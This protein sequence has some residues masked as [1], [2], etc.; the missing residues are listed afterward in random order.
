MGFLD[1]FKA[2]MKAG[3][4]AADSIIERQRAEKAAAEAAARPKPEARPQQSRLPEGVVMVNLNRL[5]PIE[6]GVNSKGQNVLLTVNGTLHAKPLGQTALDADAQRNEIRNIAREVIIREMKPQID[7]MGDL[8]FLMKSA[9][10]LNRTVC[11]ELS[12][13]GYQAAFR[14]PMVIR[15]N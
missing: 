4:E 1:N 12:V 3:S 2:A 6:L 10:D 15:P 5:Q 8:K 11:E 13:R 14:I 7:S 9:N